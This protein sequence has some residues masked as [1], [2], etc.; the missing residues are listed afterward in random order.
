MT[1]LVPATPQLGLVVATHGRHCWVESLGG[2]TGGD[3]GG[4]RRKCHQRGKRSDV[5]VGDRVVW[6]PT[7][8]SGTEGLIT[9]VQARR[10]VLM[11]QMDG[12]TKS[13]AANLDQLIVMVAVEPVFSESQLAR[14]LIA[15]QDA[16]IAARILLNKIDLPG[17]AA[18][19]ER[20]APYVRMGME[21]IGVS[22]KTDAAAALA[23]L[24]PALSGRASLIIGPSGAGKSS[25]VNRL[26]PGASALVG[27][28]STAL[29]SGR[30]TTTASHWYWLD[31]EHAGAII[32]SP[33]FQEFGLAHISAQ[34]LPLLMPDIAAHASD[35]RFYN[36]THLAEP[37]CGVRA[38][39]EAGSI[40]ASRYRIYGE[41]RGGGAAG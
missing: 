18:A 6:Q 10:N 11:R 13:F 39:V 8:A 14:A 29:N 19:I 20:L 41:I 26:V 37:G 38:A 17:A 28:I 16:G 27:E 2:S 1:G 33:G 35:C 24:Q 32:D 5:V 15:A 7:D 9:A 22:V 3:S 31:A 40:S 30:H 21:V 34:Q 23:R 36:C 12:K 4:V 25:L